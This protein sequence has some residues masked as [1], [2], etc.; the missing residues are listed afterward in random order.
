MIKVILIITIFWISL[1]EVLSQDFVFTWRVYP[2]A[3]ES[4]NITVF[5]KEKKMFLKVVETYSKDSL[6]TKI[7]KIDCDSLYNFCINYS[8]PTKGNTITHIYREYFDTVEYGDKDRI[9]LNGDTIFRARF[10]RYYLKWDND[11]NKLYREQEY[12]IHITD[13]D[14]YFGTFKTDTVHFRYSVHSGRIDENDYA[15]NLLVVY[16]MKKYNKGMQ[17]E[18]F[19]KAVEYNKPV[20]YRHK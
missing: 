13:G 19:I 5:R 6:I 4:F 1:S 14:T 8:F 10:E 18:R 3:G 20:T 12:Y 11:S 15:L 17:L 7:S 16:L 9:I 2:F